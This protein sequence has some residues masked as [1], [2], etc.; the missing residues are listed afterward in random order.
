MKHNMPRTRP[1]H[2]FHCLEEQQ[3]QRPCSLHPAADNCNPC[4]VDADIGICGTPCHPFSMQRS[5]RFQPQS[6]EK[7]HECDVALKHFLTWME[8]FE[9]SVQIFE[10][11]LGF[12]MP[13][14]TG[15]QETPLSRLRVC[16]IIIA[17]E[18]NSGSYCSCVGM[19][20]LTLLCLCATFPKP[21]PC[22]YSE[23][24]TTA[25]IFSNLQASGGWREICLSML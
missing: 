20:S 23:Y 15:S 19:L 9:P 18:R 24:P 5:A 13:F 14:E 11:V 3:L 21:Q 16:R 10:Q 2:W 4:P 1:T 12:S 6:V 22:R 17:S 7:H 8:T 25:R